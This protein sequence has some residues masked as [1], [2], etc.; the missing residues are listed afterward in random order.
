M[1]N[2]DI[3]LL[4]VPNI[5]YP[6]RL[7]HS[8]FAIF[9]KKLEY[10]K[11]KNAVLK[12]NDWNN[13]YLI[14]YIVYCVVF[15]ADDGDSL[16]FQMYVDA[17]QVLFKREISKEI[18][19]IIEE[20]L[21]I[22]D[23]YVVA[24]KLIYAIRQFSVEEGYLL[25]LFLSK[26]LNRTYRS[27]VVLPIDLLQGI[28]CV[29]SEYIFAYYVRGVL[30]ARIKNGKDSDLL[31]QIRCVYLNKKEY[32]I[33]ELGIQHVYLFGSVAVNEYHRESDI[34]MVISV[35]HPISKNNFD[36]V[37]KEVKDINYKNFNR[38]SDIY[39]Y[40]DFIKRNRSIDL[41]LLI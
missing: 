4:T 30:L 25:F 17:F 19:V 10:N 5:S 6:Y 34:D 32:L 2:N 13:E 29:K 39:E 7:I 27:L 40:D 37:V 3:S 38:E 23:K 28:D 33:N 20:T 16:N 24:A 9:H 12:I 26:Y 11:I 36:A 22:K 31:S 8:F 15:A 14:Y 41:C 18:L 21:S 1:T 35:K